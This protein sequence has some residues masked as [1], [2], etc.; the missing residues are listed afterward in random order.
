MRELHILS[1]LSQ[2][3]LLLRGTKQ[4]PQLSGWRLSTVEPKRLS[5]KGLTRLV[6]HAPWHFLYFFPLPQGQGSLRPTFSLL[7]WTVCG[8]AG[9]S[10]RLSLRRIGGGAEGTG[11]GGASPL[12]AWTRKS[13][14]R[15]S[16]LIRSII[17]AKRS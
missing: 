7:R 8:G 6:L 14:S 1:L 5:E 16:D 9:S 4:V 11:G 17:P 2:P 12:A 13:R 3:G 10:P 15:E